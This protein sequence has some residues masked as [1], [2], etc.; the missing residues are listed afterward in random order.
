[1]AIRQLLISMLLLQQFSHTRLILR[2][3]EKKC[4]LPSLLL[5]CSEQEPWIPVGVCYHGDQPPHLQRM[6]EEATRRSPSALQTESAGTL[7]SA[8]KVTC[9]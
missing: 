2:A 6:W 3:D 7:L 8:F 9:N 4:W 1:M 5:A